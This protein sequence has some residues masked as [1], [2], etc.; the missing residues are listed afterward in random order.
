MVRTDDAL[1]QRIRGLRSETLTAFRTEA[2]SPVRVRG[3]DSLLHDDFE[4]KC[5]A[6]GADVIVG[7]VDRV[8]P[9]DAQL[10]LVDLRLF[11]E[12]EPRKHLEIG[13]RNQD[14][15]V[16]RTFSPF[17]SRRRGFEGQKI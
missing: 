1:C 16:A 17:A 11:V 4:T 12:R 9:L 6:A 5:P 8:L 2:A 15:D 13:D 3:A 10:H 14:G 7:W